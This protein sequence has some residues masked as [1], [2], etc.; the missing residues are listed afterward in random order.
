MLSVRARGLR[1]AGGLGG[2]RQRERGVAQHDGGE[3]L[4]VR[5]REG[6]ELECA[7][8]SWLS[9]LKF[10]RTLAAFAA[11]YQFCR[12]RA[13]RISRSFPA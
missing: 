12:L 9:S 11:V 4:A 8:R 10:D 3:R 13:A 6:P 2:L 1:R 5:F 7:C